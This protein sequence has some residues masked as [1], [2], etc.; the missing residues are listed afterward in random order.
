MFPRLL[1]I[2]SGLSITFAI[3]VYHSAASGAAPFTQATAV[4]TLD[5]LNA[6]PVQEETTTARPTIL[7]EPT[8]NGP[9]SNLFTASMVVLVVALA[10]VFVSVVL[11]VAA[12]AYVVLSRPTLRDLALG[13][14]V[15]RKRVFKHLGL[16]AL[17]IFLIYLSHNIL[18]WQAQGYVARWRAELFVPPEAELK[19]PKVS[20]IQAHEEDRLR[21]QFKTIREQMKFHLSVMEFFY[22]RYFIGIIVFSFTAA[23]AAIMLVLIS[24]QGWDATGNEYLITIFFVTTTASIIYGSWAGVF[25]QEQN[26]ADNK[27]LYLLYARLHNEVLSYPATLEGVN[28]EVE[29]DELEDVISAATITPAPSPTASPPPATTETAGADEDGTPGPTLIPTMTATP[30]TTPVV[31]QPASTNLGVPYSPKDFIHYVDLQLA[32]GNIAIGFDYTRVPTFAD[33]FTLDIE[34]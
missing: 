32:K 30:T 7:P 31:V 26:I 10:G 18:L 24:R 16:I 5:P 19:F 28:Y 22:E 11:M 23:V 17:L 25:R 2:L 9:R 27:N 1:L 34:Q 12:V 13:F 33:A 14:V 3:L 8:D 15:S 4:S 6:S 20:P 29:L 21:S